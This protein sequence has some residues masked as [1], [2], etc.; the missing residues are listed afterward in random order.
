MTEAKFD[1]I[2]YMM[3]ENGILD[4]ARALRDKNYFNEQFWRYVEAAN[5]VRNW[6]NLEPLL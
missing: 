1:D 2:V 5:A 6:L 4:P 3:I